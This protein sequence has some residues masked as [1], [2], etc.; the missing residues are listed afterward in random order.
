MT[1]LDDPARLLALPWSTLEDRI[2]GC[3]TRTGDPRMVGAN[4][5]FSAGQPLETP[6]ILIECA[7]R[8]D[9]RRAIEFVG[10]HSVAF[11]LR[12]GGHCFADL[13]SS[14]AVVISLS[15]MNGVTQ[16]GD[17][18]QIGPGVLAGDLIN[19][20]APAR[21]APTGGCPLVAMGGL[22]LVGGFGFLGRKYGLAADQAIGFDAVTADGD[23]ITANAAERAD[24]FW[25]LRGAGGAGFVAVTEMTIRTRSAAPVLSC[26]ALWP[27]A[28][29]A[30]A[31]DRWQIYAPDADG[32]VNLE[33]MLV[34]PDDPAK[35]CFAKLFGVIL[36][37]E[38]AW[39]DHIAQIRRTLGPLAAD[40][41]L[42]RF[43]AADAA[44]F[45]VGLI[46]GRGAEAWLPSRPFQQTGKQFTRSAFF[47]GFVDRGLIATCLAEFARDRAFPEFREIE[48]IPWGGEYATHDG[49]SCFSH[50][51]AR[52]LVR[53]T[54][55]VGA[56][57][58]ES[59]QAHA[60]QWADAS[61]TTLASRASGRV[62]Q[63]YA[64]RDLA[65]WAH[66]YYGAALGQL[67]RVKRRYDPK[68]VFRHLQSIPPAYE[69]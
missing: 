8:E 68:N 69:D 15:A 1:T 60:R 65:N 20:L 7:G 23:F 19:A 50:R 36:G 48:F 56:R 3:V 33:I 17:L 54:A 31:I 59:L 2:G 51:G 57:A 26:Q 5:H 35:A 37:D 28:K 44:R 49:L 39:P 14:R 25:A 38:G 40:L 47:D 29:A 53:H 67:Q 34:G 43:E 18:A 4:K 16:R 21:T 45:M 55:M 66:A 46:D 6:A 13:S 41:T 9:V 63:G 24:L 64:Q 27:L 58:D 32:C 30:D 22:I 42:R 52:L 10:R 11:V 62:Y 61:A 12:S